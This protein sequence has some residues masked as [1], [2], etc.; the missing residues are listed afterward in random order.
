MPLRPLMRILALTPLAAALTLPAATLAHD[1]KVGTLAI[2]SPW[3]RATP[4]GASVGAG[5]LA[6]EN[7][8]PQAEHL[9]GANSS[10][11]GHVEIHSMTVENGVMRMGPLDDGLELAP[12]GR[13]E[14]K[15]GGYHLML[16]DLKQPLR[17]GERV[18]L[19][20]EF[21]KAG[22]VDVELVVERVGASAPTAHGRQA[23]PG[24]D[25]SR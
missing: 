4:S 13:I 23:D 25:Q 16:M 14:I 24:G 17:E 5:Y 3:A 10:V 1:Y 15:P 19:T 18:P 7:W 6:V 22:K 11:A 21:R 9:V 8:G 12:G 20:L 2:T